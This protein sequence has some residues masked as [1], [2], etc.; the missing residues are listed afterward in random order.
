MRTR[1][2]TGGEA[3]VLLDEKQIRDVNQPPRLL[4]DRLR[5]LRMRVPE[6]TRRDAAGEI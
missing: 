6:W 3:N 2:E 1:G 5:E 4:R